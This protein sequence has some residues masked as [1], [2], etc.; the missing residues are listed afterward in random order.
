MTTVIGRKL[1]KQMTFRY[2]NTDEVPQSQSSCNF[3]SNR[4]TSKD[5]V[6]IMNPMSGD[7]DTY[8]EDSTAIE[9][10]YDYHEM[11]GEEEVSTTA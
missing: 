9:N 10:A 3:E 7:S 4:F 6:I 2:M 11:P 1:I 8:H 5:A